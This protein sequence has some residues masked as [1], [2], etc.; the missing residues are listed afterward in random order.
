MRRRFLLTAFMLFALLTILSPSLAQDN[1]AEWTYMMYYNG[2]NNLES[3]IYGDLTEMQ[4]AGS[5]DQVNIVA[6]VDRAPGYTSAFG[7]WTD[8]RRFLLQ[9]E[10][11]P[12]LSHDEKLDYI[13][14]FA[15]TKPGQDYH[16]LVAPAAALRQSDP[17]TYRKKLTDQDVNPDDDAQIDRIMNNLSIGLEFNTQPL[18][19]MGEL[20]M[21]D[22]Q[23]LIDFVTWAMQTYPAKH[24]ALNI[25]THG[26][27][28]LG[29]GPDETNNNDQLQ[30]PELVQA[31][32]TIK[33]NTGIDQLDLIGFDA[34]LMGQLEVYRALVPFTKYVLAS[35]EVIPG[36]GWEYSVPFTKLTQNP[37]M[38]AKELG[39]T[40]IDD[41]MAYY[42]GPGHRT[43]VD[44]GLID[45]NKIPAVVD[46]LKAFTDSADQDTLDKLSA[47]GVARVNAQ[48]FDNETNQTID[49]YSGANIYSSIDLI[50]FMN[51][52]SGQLGIDPDLKAAAETVV[53]AAQDAIV[54]SSADAALPDAHGMA[55][56]FP[57]NSRIAQLP[58]VATYDPVPY[59]DANPNM[60]TWDTFL[61]TFHSTIDTALTPDKLKMSIEKILP[62]SGSAS[63][64]DPPVVI[65]DTDGQGIASMQFL[66]VL[67][68]DDGTNLLVDTAPLTFQSVL[69]DGTAINELP[70][71]ES[72][73]NDFAWNVETLLVSDGTTQAQSVLFINDPGVPQGVIS[74]TYV[75]QSSGEKTP[76]NLIFSTDTQA[77]LATFGT[78]ANGQVSEIP[79]KPGDQ[80][81]PNEYLVTADGIT[82]Q[83]ST[84]ALTYGI[85]PFTYKY[86]PADSGNYSIGMQITDLAGN[87]KFDVQR[88]KVDN[89]GL[90]LAWRGFK[91]VERGVNFLYP[92]GWPDPASLAND[93]G[94]IDQLEVN[95]PNGDILIYV[96]RHDGKTLDQVVQEMVDLESGLTDANVA[97]PEAFG[98]DPALS[99]WITY[100]Y[101]G[102]DGT[103]RS[104][105]VIIIDAN[106][107]IYTFDL[108]TLETRLDEAQVILDKLVDSLTFFTPFTPPELGG[109]DTSTVNLSRNTVGAHGCV[110][111]SKPLN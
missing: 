109:C 8:T 78:D 104:G 19:D 3:A 103:S 51:L 110:P 91:D 64:Y 43:Q 20:D 65:F 14:A 42:A 4:A 87:S 56:Y 9:H 58:S 33:A 12:V 74:G 25:S 84:I 86:V 5:T 70:S 89:T 11:Q 96:A 34:C 41:Y 73:G 106:D 71:G 22:P 88:V 54:Q 30:L 55:I 108:D 67:N 101:T 57:T 52:V 80:F 31:L 21:G 26:A 61:T 39:T 2:D 32:T 75:A 35:E 81:Y 13:L 72:I 79:A 60:G 59:P 10:P 29:N 17:A 68:Q 105:A 76:V 100:D 107:T 23:T 94:E 53:T 95:D 28:W 16:D 44:L 102:T 40:I 48:H 97:A 15:Y 99:Q 46:A 47:L 111:L 85:Q 66:S 45:E 36:D 92:W 18:Q 90:D 82:S 63:I 93:N 38:D 50:S 98:S 77:V 62:D 24:Y 37:T 6:Q 1:L 69:P 27:G 7:D 83:P 49:P